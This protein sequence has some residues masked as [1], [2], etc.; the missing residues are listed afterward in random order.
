MIQIQTK[1]KFSSAQGGNVKLKKKK[2]EKGQS[3]TKSVILVNEEGNRVLISQDC[4]RMR[5]HH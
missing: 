4:L 5:M 3:Q 1:K 2:T